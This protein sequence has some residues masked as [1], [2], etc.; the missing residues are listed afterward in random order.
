MAI[1]YLIGDATTPDSRGSD[2]I[3]HVCNDSGG[4]GKGFELSQG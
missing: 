1:S 4:W 3:A 2:V